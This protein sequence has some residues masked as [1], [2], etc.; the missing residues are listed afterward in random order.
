MATQ[1]L[2]SVSDCGK[3]HFCRTW[4]RTHYGRWRRNG[5]PL[6]CKERNVPLKWLN[7]AISSAG[8]D[9]LMW[10]FGRTGMGYGA[11]YPKGERQV[12]AHRWVCEK[13]H[14]PA[15]K[16]KGWAAHSCAGGHLGC[17]NPSH[18]R[19]ATPKEN[20]EDRVAHGNAPRGEGHTNAKLTEDQVIA[21][22]RLKALVSYREA[23]RR[24]GVTN[25]AVSGIW[26]RRTWAWLTA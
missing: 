9:C 8:D 25:G 6:S 4:C 17:V 7:D 12:M 14:G 19:W 26:N 24:F 1:R 16:D 21:I 13:V 10:P 3:P 2:C 15:P 23:G 22:Y 11:V 18:L 20:G 5:D